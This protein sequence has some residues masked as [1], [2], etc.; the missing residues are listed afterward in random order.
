[1]L[2]TAAARGAADLVECLLH[3]GADCGLRDRFGLSAEAHAVARGRR[4]CVDLLQVHTLQYLTHLIG[5]AGR[6]GDGAV[7][8]LLRSGTRAHLRVVGPHHTLL[9][10]AARHGRARVAGLLVRY[11]CDAT[12]VDDRGFTPAQYA[13]QYGHPTPPVLGAAT[14]AQRLFL[15]AGHVDERYEEVQAVLRGGVDPNAAVDGKGKT[16]LHMA[17]YRGHV[18]VARAL[19]AKGGRVG[20]ADRKRRTALHYAAGSSNRRGALDV[21]TALV[22]HG[23]DVHAKDYNGHKAAHFAASPTEYEAAVERG[24]QYHGEG[25]APAPVVETSRKRPAPFDLEADRPASKRCKVPPREGMAAAV[26]ALGELEEKVRA[27]AP[28]RLQDLSMEVL[29]AVGELEVAAC[30]H[31]AAQPP[32]QPVEALKQAC[33]C[34]AMH[35]GAAAAG[36]DTTQRL[37]QGLAGVGQAYRRVSGGARTDAADPTWRRGAVGVDAFGVVMKQ[38]C[39]ALQGKRCAVRLY[40]PAEAAPRVARGDGMAGR[41]RHAVLRRYED[42]VRA[43][44]EHVGLAPSLAA[45]P[46]AALQD[47]VE[48]FVAMTDAPCA[49]CGAYWH[50]EPDTLAYAPPTVFLPDKQRL[51]HKTCRP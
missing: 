34:V 32:P 23:A 19:L 47:A 30:S 9:H 42:G 48:D 15:L 5:V 37:L 25:A 24:R 2:H 38:V 14:A 3:C 29:K 8:R 1:M 22:Q 44:L 40:G 12:A 16:A 31:F 7:E 13:A 27:S 21:V 46:S 17:A 45:L 51:V 35:A 28:S 20:T 26:A 49:H 43:F 6:W 10:L 36:A 18:R 4:D 11:G 41:T 50:L 33:A 39:V